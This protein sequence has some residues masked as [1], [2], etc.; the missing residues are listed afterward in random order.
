MAYSYVINLMKHLYIIIFTCFLF[1]IGAFAQEQETDTARVHLKGRVIDDKQEPVSMCIIR[2][3][4]QATATTANLQGQYNIS[5]H[6]ADSVVVTYSMIGFTTRRRVLKKPKGNLTLNITLHENGQ[7]LG[8]VTVSD[9]KREM[10]TTQSLNKKE[11]K[12]L[13]STTGNAVEE[14]V[15]TQAGVS[16]HNELSSQYNVRG[17]SFDENCVYI[18]G[19]EVYRPLLISS[20]QQEGLS[21]INSD[22]VEKI[23]FS[24]GGFEAKYGDKMSSVLDITYARPTK[25]E[26]SVQ[27]SL[28]GVNAYAGYGNNKFSFSNG[29]RY[30]T[31]QYMLGGLETKGEYKPN[32][33]DYQAYLSWMPSKAWTIDAI[34]YISRNDYNFI[35]K[36]RETNF[37]TLDNVRSFKVYFDGKEADRFNTFFGTMKVTRKLNEKQALGLSF[38]GFSTRER[39][40]YDIQGQYWLNE[41][42]TDDQLGVGTYMEH[43]RNTLKSSSV[44]LKGTYD[45]QFKNHK[46]QAGLSWRHES[47]KEN[48]R[49]WEYRDS[50]GYSIPHTGNNLE[51]I[52]N[53]KS[54]NNISSN[55]MEFYAQD[56]YRTESKV[57]ILSVNY[58]ARL[59]Y[60]NWNKEW[61]FSPRVCL[62][63][64]PAANDNF[65]FRLAMGLYYQRPF[66]KELRD[67]ITTNGNTIVELNRDIKSQRSFQ[68]VTGMEY[69][70]KLRERLFKFTTELYYK[71][72]SNLNPY[73]V[74]NVKIVYYG[75]NC[76]SGY[77]VGV[78]FKLYG[79]FIP[80]TD[81]WISL[82]L[83]K[84]SMNLNGKKIPQP[85]DQRY[86][87]NFFFSDYFP[88]STKWKMNLKGT[89]ADGLPFGPPHTGLEKNVFRATAY[90]RVDV[91]MNYRLVDNEDRHMRRNI[92]RNVWLGLDCLN[93]F[94]F[95]NVSGYYW[96]TDVTNH[97]YAVPNYLTGRMINARVQVEF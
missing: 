27:A 64:V 81:S 74:D 28:L 2:I 45:A 76:A 57:G 94:G 68:V 41:T 18:N 32:F 47:I 79:E 35:P 26:G 24:A 10:T 16:T 7:L 14:L 21:I 9:T 40:T 90:K 48:T 69:K 30:K 93:I 50:S 1:T 61:L 3:E 51:I 8:E 49:E 20:G 82:G 52:Y 31:N 72:Q 63:F 54:I 67:T 97:Q 71:A 77:V 86:N 37:G 15:A 83:M 55:H 59:S 4:G 62:G 34:G 46:L 73:N 75:N 38:T 85:T 22:M 33:I 36:D 39:V 19:V 96:V 92:V 65:T 23:N 6:T 11:L 44:T 29:M 13:P 87:I 89:F 70:F 95:N 66:Y 58:G 53:L 88:G 60:W 25:I 42:N 43:A 80:G 17:G 56:T 5:F 78:D 91:G 12:R 84:A